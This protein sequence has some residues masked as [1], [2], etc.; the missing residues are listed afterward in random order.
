MTPTLRWCS[1]GGSYSQ[2]FDGISTG[3]GSFTTAVGWGVRVSASASFL[4][5]IATFTTAATPW[6]ASSFAN[7]ASSE[8]LAFNANTGT[9]AGST[10]RVLGIKLAGGTPNPGAA[11]TVQITDTL[12]FQNFNLSLKAQTLE[13]NGQATEWTVRAAL[14]SNPTS[15]TALGT[16]TP[17]GFGSQTV[18]LNLPTLFGSEVNNQAQNLWIQMVARRA[19]PGSGPIDVTGIDDFSLTY[20][21][22]PEPQTYALLTGLGLVGFGLWRHSR[23]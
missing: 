6:G 5:T 22:V 2:T 10:D 4:G 19:A 15:F 12:G 9:Q 7:M 17:A 23:R 11:F 18:N 21:A 16:V 20:S 1:R 13:A 3:L 8:G 14:G